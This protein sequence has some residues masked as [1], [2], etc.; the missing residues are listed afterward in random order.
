MGYVSGPRL[1][2][3]VCNAGGLGIIASA[4]MSLAELRAAIKETQAGTTGPFGVN[5]RADAPDAGDRVAAVIGAGVPV[6]SFA[7]A[8]RRELIATLKEAGVVT[9]ASVG[10]RRHAEKV[11]AWGIDA[12]IATGGE[13]GGHTGAVPT[14]LL[15][16]QLT[17]A[18]DI[19]V[20]AA[21]GF[22]DGRGLAAALAY[23]AAGIAMGTRFLL[24]RESTVPDPVKRRY[25]D[26]G[27]DGTVV[28]RRLDGRPHR[29]L[30]SDVVERDAPVDTL[31]LLRAGLVDGDPDAG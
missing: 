20:I 7:L 23:G 5:I 15:I 16:P 8:P 26:A 12:V 3:A 17:A 14:S 27:L 2:T 10:A 24:T 22:C 6:A 28:T 13:G 31:A 4:T 9:I 29:V 11:A 1:V 19:P 18:V 21:G 30:R 25:L